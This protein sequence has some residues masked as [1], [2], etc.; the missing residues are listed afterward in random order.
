V[1]PTVS[2]AAISGGVFLK[3]QGEETPALNKI[4]DASSKK[5]F[6]GTVC[7]EATSSSIRQPRSHHRNHPAF[8]SHDLSW[9]LACSGHLNIPEFAANFSARLEPAGGP[10]FR[11]TEKGELE[12][13]RKKGCPSYGIA[14][15]RVAGGKNISVEQANR[16]T[17]LQVLAKRP[18]LPPAAVAT[19]GRRR[20]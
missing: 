4:V 12:Q 2:G 3:T 19:T 18:L 10:R 5:I 17:L 9:M 14:I 16:E 7:S 1:R 20:I 8:A 15:Y 6:S 13:F 11:K